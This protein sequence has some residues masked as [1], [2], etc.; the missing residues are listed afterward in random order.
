MLC[1]VTLGLNA[2]AL[3]VLWVNLRTGSN[4]LYLTG[5]PESASLLDFLPDWPWYLMIADGIAITIFA[6][7][8][9]PFRVSRGRA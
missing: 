9:L 1:C 6:L 3:L 4:Y 8:Y 7:M 2:Y 5:R